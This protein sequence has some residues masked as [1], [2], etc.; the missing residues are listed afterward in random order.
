MSRVRWPRNRVMASAL[1]LIT[2]ITVG[3][4]FVPMSPSGSPRS[5]ARLSKSPKM[6][7]LEHEA[8]PFEEVSKAS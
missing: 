4:V 1:C 5:Q 3:A 6:W 2:V 7:Q 8:S